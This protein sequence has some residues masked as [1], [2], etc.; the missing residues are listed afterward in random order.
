MGEAWGLPD[1]ERDRERDGERLPERDLEPER[2]RLP[3]L[4]RERLFERDTERE[5]LRLRLPDFERDRDRDLSEPLSE[6]DAI[7]RLRLVAGPLLP[8]PESSPLAILRRLL[9]LSDSLVETVAL[10]TILDFCLDDNPSSICFCFLAPREP[11]LRP[12]F[13][14]ASS[15]LSDPD[16]LGAFSFFLRPAPGFRFFFSPG[17]LR[18]RSFGGRSSPP[19]PGGPEASESEM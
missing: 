8:E 1:P 11:F 14:G 6:P 15:S 17:S 19:L 16:P 4:D 5:A 18:F 13:F 7:L 3:D 9:S 12:R 2:E 10:E